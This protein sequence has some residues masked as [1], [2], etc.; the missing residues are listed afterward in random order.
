MARAEAKRAEAKRLA[1]MS[2]AARRIAMCVARMVEAR[3]L[4]AKTAAVVTAGMAA[5][6]EVMAATETANEDESC[7]CLR[8][9][10]A[11][12]L[13][14]EGR[15]ARYGAC[16]SNGKAERRREK[17]GAGERSLEEPRGAERKGEKAKLSRTCPALIAV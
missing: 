10:P 11:P 2:V 9:T 15:Q 4:K 8:R 6:Q 7:F 14:P 1:V 17:T 3:I 16:G 13:P 12:Y 5:M